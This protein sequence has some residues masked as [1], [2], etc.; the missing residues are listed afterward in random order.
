MVVGPEGNPDAPP[1]ELLE[2]AE[3]LCSKAAAFM[4]GAG[5]SLEEA[6]V[7]FVHAQCRVTELVAGFSAERQA[8]YA[9]DGEA[10]STD[11]RLAKIYAA[12]ICQPGAINAYL[13]FARQQASEILKSYWHAVEAVA[14]TLDAR[15][16]LAGADIDLLIFKAEGEAAQDRIGRA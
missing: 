13:E 15:K 9:G 10:G 5:E 4:P 14:R 7:W 16:T 11:L 12:T 3:A 2:T 1:E 6:A 8:G